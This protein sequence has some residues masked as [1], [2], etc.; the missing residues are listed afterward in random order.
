M[1]LPFVTSVLFLFA[2]QVAAQSDCNTATSVCNAIY[3]ENN[4]P[5]GEGIN[6]SEIPIGS[7]NTGEFSSAWYIFSPQS[8]GMFGFILQPQNTADDYDWSLFDIT[9]NGCAGTGNGLS[10]EISCNS[11]GSFGTNGPTGISTADGGIGNSN[12]PGDLAGPPFNEDLPVTAGRI[13]ALVVMN[14]SATLNGYSL[15][16]T[17]TAASVYD[18]VSPSVISAEANWCTGEV[19]VEFD[20][21]INVGTLSANDFV[22]NQP[23]YTITSFSTNTPNFASEFTFEISPAPFPSGLELQI[24][25]INGEVLSDLCGNELTFTSASG[26]TSP[27][28]IAVDLN[29]NFHFSS[30]TTIGCNDVGGSIT[31]EV[32]GGGPNPP[33][34]MSVD[35]VVQTGLTASDL[36]AGPHVVELT[37]NTGC[38]R[39]TSI[40]VTVLE[41]TVTMP[42]DA[43]LCDLSGSFTAV[44]SGG[45]ILWDAV[46]GITIA[47]P[48]QGTTN[49]TADAPGTYALSA[50]VTAQ[51]C[52]STA[53]FNVTFN[54]PPQSTTSLTHASCFGICDG[55]V[56]VANENAGTLTIDVGGTSITGQPAEISDLCAGQYD[57][58]IAFSPECIVTQTID[59]LQPPPVSAMFEPSSWIVD[60]EDP[61][62]VL[63]SSTENADSLVWQILGLDSVIFHDSIWNLILPQEPGMFE[64]QLTAFDTAGCSDIFN[65]QIELRDDFRFYL[66]S[67]FTP[68][69]DGINDFLIPSFTY[70]PEYYLFQIFNRFGDIVFESKDYQEVWQGDYKGNGYFVPNGVYSYIVTTRGVERDVKTYKGTITVMR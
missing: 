41:P 48:A 28:T 56:S 59:I 24:S 18:I 32:I 53:S 68:N 52:T 2:L 43:V 66:P 60:F 29:G 51:G 6:T 50:T 69:A 4:S 67:G 14:F 39:D 7:C 9:D 17:S 25:T 34:Q 15:D 27:S 10:P 16:F 58:H 38:S 31:M 55:V 11:Y 42:A 37:D 49:I 61:Q 23:G 44:F 35:G 54:N 33:Y 5:S 8:D 70:K 26:I 22:V 19:V 47:F 12:G 13:Y 3:D 20:E 30:T 62:V 63:T 45:L 21:E 57:L 65:A 1:R 36:D 64:I 40:T 46:A